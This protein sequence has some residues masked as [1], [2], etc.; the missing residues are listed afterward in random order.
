MQQLPG[1][2]G[3]HR[4]KPQPLMR[5]QLLQLQLRYGQRLRACHYNNHYNIHIIDNLN[6]LNNKHHINNINV[7]TAPAACRDTRLYEP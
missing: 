7:D 4:N 2:V 3:V 5:Q 6:N 1:H